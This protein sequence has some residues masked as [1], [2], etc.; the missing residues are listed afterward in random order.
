MFSA[1]RPWHGPATSITRVIAALP[2][3]PHPDAEEA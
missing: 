2:A 3:L 1:F